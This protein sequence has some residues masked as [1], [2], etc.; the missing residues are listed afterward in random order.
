MTRVILFTYCV[1]LYYR[2]R[3]RL[4]K[5]NMYVFLASDLSMCAQC[6]IHRMR[7]TTF[8]KLTEC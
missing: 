6:T 8:G 7:T 4:D 1:V 5:H 2:G 3:Y